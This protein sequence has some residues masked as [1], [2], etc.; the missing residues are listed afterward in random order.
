MDAL[1]NGRLR[2]RIAHVEDGVEAMTYLRRKGEYAE[3]PRPDLILLDLDMPRMN[4]QEVLAEVKADPDL[5]RIPVIMMTSSQRE[6][7][8]MKAYDL[9]VNSY[10][11][12]PVDVEKFINAVKSIEHFWFTVVKLP[13][14]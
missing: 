12:K 4:G 10:V 2:N 3:A 11:I 13:A 1:K 8:I 9:H 6:Q 5:R 14:A 7:D